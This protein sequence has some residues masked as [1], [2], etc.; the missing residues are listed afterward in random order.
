MATL[1]LMTALPISVLANGVEALGELFADKS[2]P[3]VSV[4]SL[5][6]Y[7]DGNPSEFRALPDSDGVFYFDIA[8][9]KAPEN[10]EPVRVYYRTQDNTA[11]AEWGEYESVGATEE[12]FVTLNK[13]N[14]YKARVTIQ[15]TVLES[16]FLLT[17]NY[18][19][20]VE[21]R[22]F[23]RRFH[24]E[25]TRVEGNAVLHDAD[26]KVKNDR[27]QSEFF[28]YLRAQTYLYQR[29]YAG[30]GRPSVMF[31]GS[32][33]IA[34]SKFASSTLDTPF[35]YKNGSY[36]SDMQVEFD[37]EWRKLANSDFSDLYIAVN[38]SCFEDYWNSD[39]LTTL[40]L[41]YIYQGQKRLAL[42]L[43]IEGEFDDSTYY[44]WQHAFD[45]VENNY[46][47]DK[48]YGA[49]IEDFME[50][51]FVGFTLYNN[52]GSKAFEVKMGSD[53]GDFDIEK[54]CQKLREALIEGYA[55]KV[56]TNGYYG[57]TGS[58]SLVHLRLPSDYASADSYSYEFISKSKDHKRCLSKVNISFCAYEKSRP[59]ILRDEDG[60]Q[61][62]STNINQLKE[63]DPIRM[64]IRFDHPVN[65][66][67]ISA[68]S[69]IQADIN[70]QY[71]ITLNLV[72]T[73]FAS[74]T[75]VY[76]GYLPEG[77]DD[78]KI[79]SLRNLSLQN[80]QYIKSYINQL[81][82]LSKQLDEI[83]GLNRDMRTPVAT[84]NA[85]STDSWAKS[86]SLDIYVNNKDNANARF[87]DLVTVYY[88]WSNSKELPEI[89]GSRVTFNTA[90]DGE[91]RK[92][93][94]GTGN[95]EM[96]LHIK[97]VSG[98]GKV[99]VSDAVTG[100]YD[101]SDSDAVYTPFGPYK[102][103]NA[104][105]ELSAED[106]IFSGSLKERTISLLLPDDNGGIGVQYMS[107][108]YIAKGS[109]NG[110][111]T[112]LKKFTPEQFSGDPP[113]LQYTISH[114]DVGVG[115]DVYGELTLERREV[116]FYWILSDKLGNTTEKTAEF[117]LVFDTN[118]YIES[119]ITAIGPCDISNASGD[120]QFK[121][122]TQTVDELTFIYNYKFNQDKHFT[123][124]PGTSKQV[125][126]GFY[127]AIN[128]T[129]FGNVDN[130]IYGANVHYKGELLTAGTDYTMEVT[131]GVCMI[132]F[133][134]EM[135]S[136]RYDIQLTRA[137]GDSVRVSRV[138]SVYATNGENDSTATKDKVQ[139]GTL[140]SNSVYQLS[141]QYPY[142]YYKDADGNICQEYYNGSKQPATFSTYAKAKEYVYYQEL[143]DI[144]LVKLTAATANALNSGTTGYLIAKG[145][146]MT[147]QAG[148]YWI[149]YKS[150][151]WTPTSGDSAW[152]YYYYGMNDELNEGALSMNLQSALNTVSHRIAGYGKSVI[153]TDS[154]LFLG[155][156]MGDRMLDAYG[157]P[158]LEAGQIHNIDEM[159]AKTKCG[160]AWN[161]PV[162]FAGDR[163]IY[164]SNIYVGME[165]TAEYEEYPIIG[166]V[167]LPADSVFQYM[168]Y[169][170]YSKNGEWKTLK[171]NQGQSFI[172]TL[173]ASGVYYIREIA[174]EGV[175]VYAIY[176]DKDAP[177]VNFSN[178]D[179]QGNLQEIPIDG[180]EILDVRTK[181]L[182]IG[183]IA[184]T[185]YDRLSYVAIYKV[186][187]LALVGVYTAQE[188]D[189]SPV[190]LEDGNY[191]IVVSDRSGNHYTVTA[192]VSSTGLDCQ[193]KESADKFIKLICNRRSDQ[194]LIY[195]VYL[196]GEL[197]T[198]TYA[199][200]QSFEKAG[201]YT[202]YIQDIYGNI[203][204]EEYTFQRNYPSVTWKY[205]GADGKYHEYDPS[206]TDTNGF[207]LTQVSADRY[208]ISTA[209]K[210]RFSFTEGYDF[211]F[212]GSAPTYNK[213]I[214]TE[215]TVTIEAGQS[216]TLK[217]FYKNH[218]DTYTIYSGIIDIT[219]PS[220]NV[221]TD[222]DVQVNG[223]YSLFDTWASEGEEGDIIAM[224]ELY[225]L[226]SGKRTG[227]VV[228]GGTVSSDIIK[229]DAS[230]ANELSLVEVYL[231]GALIQQQ[232]T[233]SGFS[234][235]GVSR[236]GNY[237]VVAKDTLGNISEFTF[238]NGV[239]DN[240]DY[241]V[242]GVRMDYALHGYLN[243]DLVD[244]KRVY[245]KVDYGNNHFRL[246]LKK[247]ADVFVS[248]DISGG[249][250]KIY[251]F[252][253]S[254][255]CI[256]PLMYTVTLDKND[257]KTI[258]LTVGEAILDTAAADFRFNNEYVIAK[259]GAHAIY[260]SVGTDHTVCIK[261][262][263]PTDS[264]KIA[265][266]G[267]RVEFVENGT[268]F[269]VSSEISRKSSDITFYDPDGKEISGSMTETDIR[270]NN[271]FAIDEFLFESERVSS[272]SLYYSELNDLDV[273]Q[274]VGKTDIYQSEKCY[275][276][277][278]FYILV[279]RNRFENESVYK[280]AVSRSFGVTS[281][282]TF[283]DGHKIY[284]SKDYD[285]K[286]YSN[287]EIVLD[288][289]D[290]DVIIKATLNGAAYTGFVRKQD[291]G[292]TYLVFSQEGTYEVTLTDAYGNAV[293]KRFEISKSSYTV[294]DELLTGYN[295]NALK[296]DEG[297][298]NQKL[299]VDKTVYD[300]E[301]IY[302]LAIAYGD[303]LTVLFDAFAE[304]PVVTDANGLNNVIGNDGDGV[305]QVICRNRYGAVVTKEIHY[306]GTPTLKLERTTRSKT[307]SEIY[308]LN[309]ALSLG[310]WSNNTLTFST[311]AKTYIFTVNGNATECPRTLVFEHAGDYGSTEYDITYIDEYG[312]E[313]SFKA[314]LVRKDIAIDVPTSITGIEVD[315][316]LNTKNDISILFG[317]NIYATYT[318]NN[319]E[320]VI[321]HSGDVL[322]KDGTYRF[323]VIDYAGNASTLT[324]KKDT[325]VEFSFTEANSG[326][327]ILNGSV[328]N[329]SKINFK[330]LN[331]DS[332]YIEKVLK[333]GVLQT[334]FTGSK[335]TDDGKWELILSDG[336]GNKAYFC[337]Y[338]ITH[339]QNG[340]AYT[341]PYEY[342]ITEIWY[343]S[344]DGV[345]ISYM[346]FVNHSD[347]TSSFTFTEN[348]KYTAVMTSGVTGMISTFTFT[349]NTNAPAVSLV[350]CNEGE[351]TINDIT[352]TGH[353]AG[354]RI[355]IYK[356]V[357]TG[358]VLVEQ[359]EIL[360]HS[361]KVPTINEG[362]KYR[363]VVESEAGVA[364][365][366]TFVRKHVMNT[367]GSVFILV[368]IGLSVA[369]L[370]TGL[371]YR[372]K[373]KT[374]D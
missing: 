68:S 162:Y 102:F 105:P 321:Y 57:V 233:E 329:S 93:I 336:L 168:T 186:S 130:G 312:F 60:M 291:G 131:S 157:M 12:A 346:N 217:V 226:L 250:T 75:L 281:S 249:E 272:V 150:E 49:D 191:Y 194:I 320:E 8:L 293:T 343:D 208:K 89:Y 359:V 117:T 36:T 331:K 242:D 278:G 254:D 362:G 275:T 237:R 367:A 40:N 271:G 310:F 352:I 183:S 30:I 303:T 147:P 301:G 374:D 66:V 182:I 365:E 289:M 345:K 133:H 363:I 276:D 118:D 196:N 154:S 51:N 251:G 177:K 33:Y 368:I 327:V 107:L 72:K 78:I 314:Y 31:D 103:D 279:V 121:D 129:A 16:G 348:G 235:I 135:N 13:Q 328:V 339:S 267:A 285:G 198:S 112:L 317:E 227:R 351:T 39:G 353:Q 210:M 246:D 181:D 309:Y 171:I 91:V 37:S 79:S 308:D 158:Y 247:N 53:R 77:L 52:D 46:S 62:V 219:P 153:L 92:T 63:G 87:N 263:A 199:A 178:K 370:F 369:G 214:G 6:F 290:A 258:S 364:T 88:Q 125:N 200:E 151:S 266:I 216:F 67:N 148:Q 366:L 100:T 137:E 187:N 159:S 3:V 172:D 222:L 195:E 127:F 132:W 299:S 41:Y 223:E 248:L 175:A 38:G 231:D 273:N 97:A 253:I 319:G 307:E 260:A 189:A 29:L 280:I 371:V 300:R 48:Y 170:E 332:A 340:F 142:F 141:A 34:F 101:P 288:I 205:F 268:T 138:Y 5:Y 1:I 99:S 111:G 145:E 241:F 292:T 240:M 212:I 45:Y 207:I 35:I 58:D 134:T 270:T 163:N 61:M 298:T 201:L 180:V 355:L 83:Y 11:V 295:E 257:N 220:I 80:G 232:T 119:E 86:K 224:K 306:R 27:D 204:S 120:A 174:Q 28:C 18:T 193:I 85:K 139:A 26:P 24:F 334:D 188:L 373:S 10:D 149:R 21:N 221:S 126:Y 32:K 64:T 296:R 56:D 23:T 173:K 54:V 243:F 104:A 74:D 354:D 305:Y 71:P 325:T 82:L 146:T 179:E 347:F 140:L 349:I 190:K 98:Y 109:E 73:G 192:K 265:S 338:M 326:T 297:Y 252:R 274:L 315:G 344:G 166:N 123:L 213:S 156:V 7:D 294:A 94:S 14:K 108:Y 9:D 255:G 372:N 115:V 161:M 318:R 19:N 337:F 264:S 316:I 313:Y 330:A 234:Q 164:K 143:G 269:F 225:Y 169:G 350:G 106:I 65:N 167:A 122:T 44:G 202:I 84:V 229:I 4:T 185:E 282:V 50:D 261:V 335:F 124:Y 311:D 211:E 323:T 218:R 244:G 230:D 341:T 262:Y 358:E 245:N 22:I 197:L 287:S 215:T 239:P 76:K 81:E 128:P 2:L 238:T 47:D 236:W 228:N 15:S 69:S 110:E 304:N 283:G 70:G 284:Y 43:Y 165:G 342:H 256:Y 324:I 360:S 322:K 59:S 25:L 152:V 302:Y 176:V 20:P 155:S 55:V 259:N 209:V 42:S 357:D 206:N 113:T 184:A 277:E 361:T 95:G 116:K 136:G 356:T 160:N 17:D 286:M 144:Y 333:D 203:F 114:R 96:Y 90:V